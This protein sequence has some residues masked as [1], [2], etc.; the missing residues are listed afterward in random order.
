MALSTLV[1]SCLSLDEVSCGKKSMG[2]E[3]APS[4]NL[5]N[6]V[7]GDG[8]PYEK[9][10]NGQRS[11]S[12]KDT[13]A[14]ALD[15]MVVVGVKVVRDH[16]NVLEKLND[17]AM[18]SWCLRVSDAVLSWKSQ[19]LMFLASVFWQQVVFFGRF[20][21]ILFGVCFQLFLIVFLCCKCYASLLLLSSSENV[22][23][24]RLFHAALAASGFPFLDENAEK[25]K[26]HIG[27]TR[28]ALV[29]CSC[30]NGKCERQALVYLILSNS[31]EIF[32]KNKMRSL[33]FKP[34]RST[35]I[36]RMLASISDVPQTE[37]ASP[38]ASDMSSSAQ[39]LDD[40]NPFCCWK[41]AQFGKISWRVIR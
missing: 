6:T 30:Q 29:A 8:L 2:C 38:S 27:R 15:I 19:L 36:R 17:E 21:S 13:T 33:S 34:A 35:S 18:I 16:G 12:K 9:G 37:E 28:L 40:T 39:E 25:K 7:P 20:S 1:S 24:A 22:S 4:A 41:I 3:D 11:I 10:D 14:K 32:S 23:K 5:S 26:K 31:S